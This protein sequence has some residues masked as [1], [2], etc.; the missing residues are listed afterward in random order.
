VK[1]T[2]LLEN[3]SLSEDLESRH[4]LSLFIETCDTALLFDL[5]PDD[6]AMGNA[7]KMKIDTHLKQQLGDRLFALSTG[8]QILI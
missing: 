5:G 7:A 6:K 2:C 1:I 3:T 8:L 4:G